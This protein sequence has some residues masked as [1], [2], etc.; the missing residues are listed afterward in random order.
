MLKK[1]FSNE[2]A[3]GSLI[4]FIMLNLFNALNYVYHFL[5][6]RMLGPA[7]YGILV[8]LMSLG[9]IL[10]IPSEAIQNLFSKYTS[11]LNKN[12]DLRGLG[13]LIRR[14]SFLG[15]LWGGGGFLILA[16]LSIWLS[17]FLRINYWLIILTNLFLL[18]GVLSPIAKGVLQGRKKFFELGM[19]FVVEGVLKIILA[20]ILVI[21]GFRVYGA[22][23]AVIFGTFA[24]FVLG[25]YY[26]RTILNQN[27]KK[28]SL[29]DFEVENKDYFLVVFTI[30]LILGIDVILARR[31]FSEEIA[32]QYSVLAMMG[33]I[34]YFATMSIG[35]S[36]FPLT[37]ES[38]E[39]K[40][41]SKKIFG[42]AFLTVGGLC[43]IA[44]VLYFLI[45]K[46]IISL[47]YGKDYLEFASYLGIAGISASLLSLSNLVFQYGLSTQG[48]RFRWGMVA[49]SVGVL[50]GL[51]LFHETL[52]QFMTAFMI[53]NVL[54]F[55]LSFLFLKNENQYNNS[56]I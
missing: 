46:V 47:L 29:K 38:H 12:K 35:K 6:G 22:M 14:G 3:R 52:L 33:R 36:M 8:V 31:F 9:Y 44:V 32:G 27:P 40:R 39:K 16:V 41:N 19:S 23:G 49:L 5:M 30:L 45:P 24:G 50:G 18:I 51:F 17:N 42:Q 48:I 7:D 34:I 43:L 15:I 13:G 10:T 53:G 11:K 25:I 2:F 28:V 1:I 21:L 54:I 37:S 56:R 55:L 26:N 20:V 4:L